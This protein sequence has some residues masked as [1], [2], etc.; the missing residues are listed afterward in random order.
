MAAIRWPDTRLGRLLDRIER[1]YGPPPLP[2]FAGP[3]EMILW[4]I[5]AY[6]ADDARRGVAF[7]ALRKQVGLTPQKILAAPKNLLCDITRMGGSIAAEERAER[8]QMAAQLTMDQFGGDL[9][10]L[11]KLPPQKA[12]KLLMQ[13]PMVGEPGAEKILMFSGALAVLALESNGLRV[14]VRMGC[15]EDRKSYSATYKS[16]REVTLEELPVDCRLL[17]KAHLLLREH[18]RRLCL[19][20]G[21]VCPA[22]P[23]KSD[24]TFFLGPK[25][26][27]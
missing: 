23:V 24:C 3:F 7:D 9:D 27:P 11:L 19:R 6:L 17:T 12:K 1:H 20:N 22:C 18:G 21:P 13:F 14:L 5:V 15:G 25:L 4:E 26:T 10:S 8:L 16:V 2:P